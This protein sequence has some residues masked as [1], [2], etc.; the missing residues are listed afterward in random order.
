MRSSG[1]AGIRASA[2][3][4]DGAVRP[5]APYGARRPVDRDRTVEPRRTIYPL[6]GPLWAD[7]HGTEWRVEVELVERAQRGDAE[8]FDSMARLVGDSCL[9]IA[10][11]ILRDLDLAED[12]V[13]GA[14]ITA[15]RELR[16]LRDPSR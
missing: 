4:P 9:A 15:W 16:T 2:T 3:V 10:V 12:A 1:E 11:R 6:N 7:H 8:A 14:L 13:Q 5:S